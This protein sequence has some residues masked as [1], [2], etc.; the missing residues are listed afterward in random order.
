M[1]TESGKYTYRVVEDWGRGPEGR[2]EP[3]LV[4]DVAVDS[5]DRV[6]AFVREPQ[7]GVLV[8]DRDGRLLTSWGEG[9]FT[10]PHGIWI[11]SDDL[12]YLADSGN[13]TIRICIADGTVNQT[14][15]I[16]G[17]P[18]PPDMPFNLPT[19]AALSPS[20]DIFV[21][22]GYGQ[23]RVHRFA[24]D[25]SL[26]LS[27]G[28]QGEGPRQF[29]LPHSIWVDRLGRVLV[30]DR[31]NNRIQIFDAVGTFLGE[32]SDLVLP[33]SLFIDQD[34]IVYVA[35]VNQRISIFNLEGE[36]LGRW[37]EEGDAPGQ[38]NN[39]PHGICGDSHGDLYICEVI[40]ENRLQK[41]ERV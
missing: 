40:G 8:F 13:H 4:T 24:P 23:F 31:E 19:K 5:R 41:F 10:Q 33:M 26:Q 25:G 30:A 9:M 34:D 12:I 3:G 37:G 2:S 16:P 36:L 38:F 21:S 29:A 27:W 7:P 28:E 18:G 22:D 15:G 6:Y 32:W 20:G 1:V 17:Q 14:L 11:S 39:Y 35:E